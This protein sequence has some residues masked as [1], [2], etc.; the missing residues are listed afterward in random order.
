MEPYHHLS[1]AHQPGR[2]LLEI[3][4][5]GI[6]DQH[7]RKN[8]DAVTPGQQF[9]SRIRH[10]KILKMRNNLDPE[11][12]RERTADIVQLLLDIADN[13]EVISLCRQL[14]GE[15]ETDTGTSSG[16]QCYHNSA[17]AFSISLLS[18]FG[19]FSTQ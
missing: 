1:L 12:L 17:S 13:D 4:H 19:I 11:L 15:L 16:H 5:P 3:E 10:C 6:I 18:D 7:V 2:E 14:A 8:G 9:L